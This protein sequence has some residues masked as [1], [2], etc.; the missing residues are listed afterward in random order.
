MKKLAF[1]LILGL[2][3]ALPLVMVT[4]AW[5][6]AGSE[7]VIPASSDLGCQ[8]C[9]PAFYTSWKHSAHGMATE[10]P[11]FV[12]S[13]QAGGEPFECLICHTTGYDPRTQTWEEDGITCSA[14]HGPLVENHPNEPMP[15]TS[16]PELC[17]SCH[18]ETLFEWQVSKYRQANMECVDCHGQHSTSL[19]A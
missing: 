9:H 10:D 19:K 16:S 7:P 18:T 17:G 8:A 3:F 14:C 13:W 1:R 2:C 4:T 12:E 11:V 6:Q 15:N 5:A